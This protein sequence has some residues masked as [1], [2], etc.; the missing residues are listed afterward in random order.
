MKKKLT[1]N[2]LYYHFFIDDFGIKTD[3]N[4]IIVII[5]LYKQVKC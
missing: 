1:P 3:I 4:L 2:T 5:I